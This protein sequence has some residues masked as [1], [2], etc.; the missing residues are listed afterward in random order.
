MALGSRAEEFRAV[1][2]RDVALTTFLYYFNLGKVLPFKSV[3]K[4][5]YLMLLGGKFPFLSSPP[6]WL[7]ARLI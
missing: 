5:L 3:P 1:V 7:I 4:F 6:K 2:W